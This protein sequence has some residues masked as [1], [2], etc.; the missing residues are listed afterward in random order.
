MTKNNYPEKR[1]FTRITIET[2]VSFATNDNGED[3]YNG[4]S[5]NLSAGGIYLTT[6]HSLKLANHIKIVFNENDS[7]NLVAEG[8]I[9]RCKFD[10]KDPNLF[11]VSVEFSETSQYLEHF[12]TNSMVKNT[13]N[14]G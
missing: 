6:D 13:N 9:V 14:Y 12:I 1:Q 4:T 2:Q 7:S 8:H 5:Q 3:S 11:H 10:K